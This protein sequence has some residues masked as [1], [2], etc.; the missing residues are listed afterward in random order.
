MGHLETELNY[1]GSISYILL[2][3]H[4]RRLMCPEDKEVLLSSQAPLY[5]LFLWLALICI[6]SPTIH[7]TLNITDFSKFCEF[8]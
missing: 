1:A 4:V 2:H 5:A 3:I 7:V 6:L 8:F